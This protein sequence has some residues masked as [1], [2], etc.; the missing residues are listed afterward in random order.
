VGLRRRWPFRHMGPR[1]RG[2]R[3]ATPSSRSLVE[4]LGRR[5][6]RETSAEVDPSDATPRRC[7]FVELRSVWTAAL[8]KVAYRGA[9]TK[10]EM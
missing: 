6:D 4:E 10:V 9:K 8:M 2:G 5:P 3:M 1:V 7:A